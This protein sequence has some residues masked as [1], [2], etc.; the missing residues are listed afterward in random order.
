MTTIDPESI[1]RFWSYIP[2]M[3]DNRCWHWRGTVRIAGYPVLTVGGV[4]V[5]A[6][7]FALVYLNGVRLTFNSVKHTCGNKDCCNPKHLFSTEHPIPANLPNVTEDAYLT[8]TRKPRTGVPYNAKF[9]PE[10]VREVCVRHFE[11]ATPL[12]LACDYTVSIK[13]ITDIIKGVSYRQVPRP[14]KGPQ[15]TA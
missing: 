14:Q 5:R 10:Q 8:P 9:T 1:Q 15:K 7:V 2:S 13:T 12:E 11:G 4:R 6:C 3:P